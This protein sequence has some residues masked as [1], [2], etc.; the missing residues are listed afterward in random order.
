MKK[1][2][3][4]LIRLYRLCLSPFLGQCCRFAP[5]CSA[6]AEE[7]YETYGVIKGTRMVIMRLIK[8]GPWHPGGYDP[9]EKGI[10]LEAEF[11][12]SSPDESLNCSIDL[13]ASKH[14]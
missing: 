2:L 9:V 8:C 1:F 12:S 13:P 3:I 11:S 5:S 7:A 14:Q 6:Y 4:L 10:N